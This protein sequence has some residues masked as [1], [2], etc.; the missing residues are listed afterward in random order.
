MPKKQIFDESKE[1][2]TELMENLFKKLIG[3]QKPKR[4]RKITD[5]RREQLREQLKKGREMS[6]ISRTETAKKKREQ[7]EQPDAPPP[8]PVKEALPKQTDLSQLESKF[9]NMINHLKDIST[10]QKET[11]EHKKQ[12]NQKKK[13]KDDDDAI[14]WLKPSKQEKKEAPPPAKQQQQQ[15]QQ[16][17][18]LPPPTQHIPK[19]YFVPTPNNK[20]L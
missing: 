15:Q 10:M 17:Q 18:Q 13:E 14:D 9:D 11:L 4:T 7:K 16:Q 20:I 3:Q 19:F 8:S 1:T 12:K 5:E 6:I 2:E